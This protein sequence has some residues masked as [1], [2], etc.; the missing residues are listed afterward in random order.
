MLVSTIN[1]HKL[2]RSDFMV[3]FTS[4]IK[5]LEF[6]LNVFIEFRDKNICH[7][8][9]R[10]QTCHLLCMRPGCYHSTS[11]THIRDRIFKWVP[12]HAS[13]ILIGFPAFAKFTEFNESSDPIRK[14]LLKNLLNF[15]TEI[16]DEM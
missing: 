11:K 4:K 7:Y 14:N 5:R 8:S 6:F 2:W 12:I 16:P 15:H 9:E 3:I 13:V 10:S 1:R